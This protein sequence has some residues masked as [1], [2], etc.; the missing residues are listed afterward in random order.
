MNVY[1]FGPKI[2]VEKF[3]IYIIKNY[4]LITYTFTPNDF[5]HK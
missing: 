4:L 5:L 3:V 1:E 2:N